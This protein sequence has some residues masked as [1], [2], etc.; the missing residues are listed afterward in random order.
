MGKIFQLGGLF[1][2]SRYF[3]FPLQ[4]GGIMCPLAINFPICMRKII[5]IM[6][7]IAT[8]TFLDTD[9]LCLCP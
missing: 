5:A 8:I 7:K 1:N 9:C 3:I 2:F 4:F 6:Q